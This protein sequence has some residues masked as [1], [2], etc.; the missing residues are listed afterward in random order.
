MDTGKKERKLYGT[1]TSDFT[2]KMMAGSNSLN[3]VQWDSDG[4][5]LV[6]HETRAKLGVLMA[7]QA[8]HA[9]RSLTDSTY[10]I[11]GSVGYGGGEFT[12]HQ[13]VVFFACKNRLYRHA[14]DYGN[15]TPITPAFGGVA[16]PSVSHDGAYVAYVHSY[17]GQ[18][19]ILIVDTHGKQFPQK[20]VSGNDFVM[21]PTWHPQGTHLAV[22]AWDFPH[23]PWSQTQLRLI[24]LAYDKQHHP[25]NAIEETLVSGDDVAVQQPQF[26][27]DGRYLTYV[28]DATGWGHLYIYDLADGTHTQLTSGEIEHGVPPWVQGIRHYGWTSDNRGIY[29]LRADKCFSSVWRYDLH[30]QTHT[31]IEGLDEYTHMTQLAVA[32]KGE[33]FAVLA[34]SSVIP[35]RVLSYTATEGVRVVARATT[36]RL[37]LHTLSP[38]QPISWTSFDG[39]TAHGLYYAPVSARYEGIGKPPLIVIVHGGPTSQRNPA[40]EGA[41]QYFATRGYAVLNVN[42]RGST[43]YGKAYMNKQRHLW[44][45]HDTEDSRSGALYLAE[46]GLVDRDKM[47]IMGSSAG[48]FTVLMTLAHHVGV[49]KVGVNLFG[50]SNQFAII[51]DMDFKFESRYY[52]WLL[53]ALPDAAPRWRA[54]SPMLDA[55]LIRDALITFQGTDDTV[56]PKS[57]S[58]MLIDALRVNGV[59]HEYHVYEG[60]GHGFGKPST[61]EDMYTKIER[62]LLQ[63]VLYT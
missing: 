16:S 40:Y 26:S 46:Q 24:T 5:T 4:H 14:L 17:E 15:P 1:W 32:P 31:H 36:E 22:I 60:E 34:S 7:Q 45:V 30:T 41:P 50:V 59:T 23:M 27:P 39:E 19:N 53:G 13:G 29:Y 37:A 2:P 61:I 63:H 3:D 57:Q 33:R 44:G 11:G 18:D 9:S 47:V 10:N 51:Q 42:Y 62:F 58:D 25:Y 54:S 28:S 6:W 43:G 48:G 8:S 35:P 12:V 49:F 56:V 21:Q 55:H 52:E 20:L 38:A